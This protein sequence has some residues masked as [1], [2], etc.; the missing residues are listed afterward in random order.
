M[1]LILIVA[2]VLIAWSL[3]LMRQAFAQHE[4]SLMLAGTLVA[5]AAAATIGVYFLMG[6]YMLYIEEMAQRSATLNLSQHPYPVAAF[7]W[8]DAENLT[9][10]TLELSFLLR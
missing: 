4:L 1:S 8:Q 9:P 2:I 7:T 3:H 5:M 6:D 10:E